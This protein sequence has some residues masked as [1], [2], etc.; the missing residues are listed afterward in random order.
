MASDIACSAGYQNIHYVDSLCK[1]HLLKLVSADIG[2]LQATPSAGVVRSS[3]WPGSCRT[4]HQEAE[5]A[6]SLHGGWSVMMSA[7]VGIGKTGHRPVQNFLQPC[8]ASADFVILLLDRQ[9]R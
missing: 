4:R 5:I 7:A 1:E 6:N 8:F 9:G 2:H 3:D